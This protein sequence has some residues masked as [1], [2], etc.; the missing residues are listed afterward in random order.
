M[1][2][3]PGGKSSAKFSMNTQKDNI[4]IFLQKKPDCRSRQTDVTKNHDLR[5]RADGTATK[6]LYRS[7]IFFLN[8]NATIMNSYF[9]P[10][11]NNINRWNISLLSLEKQAGIGTFLPACIRQKRHCLSDRNSYPH[12]IFFSGELSVAMRHGL[13]TGR[14]PAPDVFR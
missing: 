5:N 12:K 10:L 11:F 9:C 13:S 2:R 3:K 6:N 8:L 14:I 1:R 7:V 4:N